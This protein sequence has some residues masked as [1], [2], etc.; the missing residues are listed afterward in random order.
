MKHFVKLLVVIVVLIGNSSGQTEKRITEWLEVSRPEH[1]FSLEAPAGFQF[2]M[3]GFPNDN[4]V[5]RGEYHT[6]LDRFYI[7]VDRPTKQTQRQKVEEYLT[8]ANQA[9]SSFDFHRNDARRVEFADSEGFYHRVVFV[10]T[11]N[12]VFTLHTVSLRRDSLDAIRFLNSFKLQP[13]AAIDSAVAE[14]IFPASPT[15][16]LTTA[17]S[18]SESRS[19]A[20]GSSGTTASTTSRV[21]T[22][23]RIHYK[24]KASYTDF[25]RFYGIQGNVLLRVTFLASGEIGAVTKIRSLPFGLTESAIEAA[26]Q[27]RFEPESV[28]GVARNTTR[29]VSYTFNIF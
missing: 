20:G 27:M 4:V 9:T 7:F 13:T 19:A 16:E 29:P 23:L 5:G 24:H 3:P 6:E 10:Q 22:P 2:R 1:E 8:F 12:R 28:D 11:L 25:A 15:S 17:Q 14:P 26:R 18:P 21:T